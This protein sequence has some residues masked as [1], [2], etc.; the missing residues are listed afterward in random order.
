MKIFIDSRNTPFLCSNSKYSSTISIICTNTFNNVKFV[1]DILPSLFFKYV[2]IV[3]STLFFNK[4]DNFYINLPLCTYIEFIL[5]IFN[6]FP[7]L[8]GISFSN[9][10]NKLRQ[11]WSKQRWRAEIF[12]V[13]IFSYWRAFAYKMSSRV[14]LL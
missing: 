13:F 2:S 10:D 6:Y 3:N 1:L 11:L 4:F 14:R 5:P 9:F 8:N 12:L 7:S